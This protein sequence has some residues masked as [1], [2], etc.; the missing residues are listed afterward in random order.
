MIVGI[1][2][3]WPF[4][5]RTGNS[6]KDTIDIFFIRAQSRFSRLLFCVES[7]TTDVLKGA[8]EF[9]HAADVIVFACTENTMTTTSIGR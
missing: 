6:S 2:G 8:I 3:L 1:D 4:V 7:D 5:L 9:S